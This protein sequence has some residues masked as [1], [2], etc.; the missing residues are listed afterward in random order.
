MIVAFPRVSVKYYINLVSYPLHFRL[1]SR[2]NISRSNEKISGLTVG[3]AV[4]LIRVS[5]MWTN[6][7]I[8]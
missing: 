2:V 6:V 1:F 7:H 5:Y 3:I 4:D 8:V